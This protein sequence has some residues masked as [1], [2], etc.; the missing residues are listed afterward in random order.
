MSHDDE[1]SQISFLQGL[2][3]NYYLIVVFFAAAL[4]GGIYALSAREDAIRKDAEHRAQIE[5]ERKTK[6]PPILTLKESEGF[7]FASGKS[8]IPE[9]FAAKL[10]DVIIPSL[11][12]N[13]AEFDAKLVEVV[14]HTDELSYSPPYTKHRVQGDRYV[15]MAGNL[16]QL[17]VPYLN[18]TEAYPID[19]RPYDNT[20][21]GMARA[22]AVA[23]IL[24]Q[25]PRCSGLTVMAFSAGQ[26]ITSAGALSNGGIKPS[27][28]AGRRRIE[29]RVRRD[30][31]MANN[32]NGATT[33]PKP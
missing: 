16:D 1:E 23:R 13:A 33:A 14:G 11:L 29:I 26:T 30:G 28:D 21:L 5:I 19:L 9:D 18:G 6:P 15:Q 10:R 20:G 17:L 22:A 8:D 24:K 2:D 4:L 7:V 25:D 32:G 27:S 3:V 12:R 31:N